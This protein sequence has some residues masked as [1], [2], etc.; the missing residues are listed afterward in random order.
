MGHAS[1]FIKN[2]DVCN[3]L[4]FFNL[5]FPSL[6]HSFILLFTKVRPI[7]SLSLSP[8]SPAT[9]TPHSKQ[10]AFPLGYSAYFSANL[11]DSVGRQFD[12]AG[13]DLSYRL[14]RFDIVHITRGIGDES[15]IVKAA[16]Q[17][18]VILKVD[19]YLC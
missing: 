11:H 15:Y 18:N 10:H 3:K 9:A 16:K 17:G 7:A 1:K 14:N 13:I 6:S 19:I 4:I 12:Y 8:I 5:F 2:S